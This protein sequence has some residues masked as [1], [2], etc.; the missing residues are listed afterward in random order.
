MMVFS[1]YNPDAPLEHIDVKI[2]GR[3]NFEKILANSVKMST[4]G[5]EIPVASIDDLI[6]LKTKA[7]RERD[8]IDI[9]VLRKLQNYGRQ[10]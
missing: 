2:D 8:L 9:K 4:D 6:E 3:E 5:F 7:G 10:K 1:V